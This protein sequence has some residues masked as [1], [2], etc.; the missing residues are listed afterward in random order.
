MDMT[1]WNLKQEL[2]AS[3]TYATAARCLRELIE[4]KKA[5]PPA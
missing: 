4:D 2:A 5:K 3:R 1:R